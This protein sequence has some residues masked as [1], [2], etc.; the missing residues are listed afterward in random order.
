VLAVELVLLEAAEEVEEADEAFA[1]EVVDVP[2]SVP[3]PLHA[4]SRQTRS[5]PATKPGERLPERA[6]WNCM[7][8]PLVVKLLFK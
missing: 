4:C 6:N 1:D 5:V 3:P 2:E 8:S 7:M